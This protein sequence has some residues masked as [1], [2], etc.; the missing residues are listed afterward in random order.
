MKAGFED[1]AG[2]ILGQIRRH[3]A[4]VL[5]YGVRFVV[6]RQMK[7]FRVPTDAVRDVSK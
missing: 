3:R 4:G 5:I 1:S 6:E 2:R 7:G